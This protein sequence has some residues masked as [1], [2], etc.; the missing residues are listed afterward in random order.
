MIT[1]CP[2][3]GHNL[4]KPLV[5]GI[6][7]CPNCNR[8]F[9]SSRL[10]RLLSGAWIIRRSHVAEAEFLIWRHGFDRED[11]EFLV[12]T[13]YDGCRT[14]DEAI[15]MIEEQSLKQPAPESGCTL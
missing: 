3:C 12:E 1:L 10:N 14:H 7:S 8:V 2:C 5:R 13:V 4:P 6:T 9:D 11:A 15:K